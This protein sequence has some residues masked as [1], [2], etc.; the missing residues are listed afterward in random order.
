MSKPIGL[1]VVWII[2]ILFFCHTVG[3]G[4]EKSAPKPLVPMIPPE[5]RTPT[6][7]RPRASFTLDSPEEMSK[8][9]RNLEVARSSCVH[10]LNQFARGENK[11]EKKAAWAAWFLAEIRSDEEQSILAL[12][13]N[14]GKGIRAGDDEWGV[15]HS[16]S[17]RGAAAALVKIGGS[18]A[19]DT[20]IGRMRH[21]VSEYELRTYAYVFYA[22]DKTPL[23]IRHLELAIER[24]KKTPV[25]PSPDKKY[26]E[27]LDFIKDALSKPGYLSDQKNWPSRRL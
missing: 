11:D 5:V 24:E 13:A 23:T 9:S 7:N 17:G 25:F 18:R 26:L 14:I 3:S 10:F 15:P 20:M 12:C 21:E 22:M 4:Q 2:G 27:R 16:L 1:L 19:K 8:L 6:D